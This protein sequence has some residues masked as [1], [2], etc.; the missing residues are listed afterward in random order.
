MLFGVPITRLIGYALVF[1][2]GGAGALWAYLGEPG[3][4]APIASIAAIVV[5]IFL[6]RP[7]E[8]T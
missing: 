2:G 3:W 1:L 6:P 4:Y 7:A 5:G 8:H